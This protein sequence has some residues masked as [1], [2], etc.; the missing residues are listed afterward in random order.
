MM[1]ESLSVDF[2]LYNLL[3]EKITIDFLPRVMEKERGKVKHIAT[4]VLPSEHERQ[5]FGQHRGLCR[6][7]DLL[8]I[9]LLCR[10]PE[11]T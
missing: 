10:L 7:D 9:S 1:S 8:F 2:S 4:S 6:I 11:G 5:C 3:K